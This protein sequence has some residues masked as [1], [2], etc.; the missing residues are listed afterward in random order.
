M[1]LDTYNLFNRSF[2]LGDTAC[3]ERNHSLTIFLG[4]CWLLLNGILFLDIKFP[5]IITNRVR[6]AAPRKI[7]CP[8]WGPPSGSQVACLILFHRPSPYMQMRVPYKK[9]IKE[10]ANNFFSSAV[11]CTMTERIETL[12]RND[13]TQGKDVFQVQVLKE[14]EKKKKS[15]EKKKSDEAEKSPVL[16]SAD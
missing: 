12:D 1:C 13:D 14:A 2:V 16:T 7:R 10:F 5:C 8:F 4:I 6:L 11:R 9:L 15:E 3:Q